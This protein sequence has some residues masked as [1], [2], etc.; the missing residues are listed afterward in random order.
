MADI[1]YVVAEIIGEE[2]KRR[3]KEQTT[4]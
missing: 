1:E 3:M 2:K 4:G